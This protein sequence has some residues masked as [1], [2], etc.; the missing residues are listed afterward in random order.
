MQTWQVNCQSNGLLVILITGLVLASAVLFYRRLRGSIPRGRWGLLL[1]LRLVGILVLLLL[2][3]KPAIGFRAGSAHLSAP[4]LLVDVSKSMG[5]ADRPGESR[6]EFVKGLLAEN[7]DLLTQAPPAR[8]FT[9]A[10]GLAPVA[11]DRLESLEAGG[12][13]TDL[14]GALRSVEQAISTDRIQAVVLFSDGNHLGPSDPVAAAAGL[15]RPV[16]S[17][18]VGSADTAYGTGR[19]ALALPDPPVKMI[20]GADNPVSTEVRWQSLQPGNWRL[21]VA[22]NEKRG[23]PKTIALTT[24]AG[25]RTLEVKIRPDGAG[26]TVCRLQL[27]GPA[28]QGVDA[29]APREFHTL[30]VPEKIRVLMVEGQVRPEYKFLKQYLQSDPAVTFAGF[31][32]IRPGKFLVTSLIPGYQP[33][34]LPTTKAEFDRFDLVILGDISPRTFSPGQVRCLKDLVSGGRGLLLIPGQETGDLK[35]GPLADLL[36][37]VLAPKTAWIDSPFLPRLTVAGR[38]AP[39][40]KGLENFFRNDARLQ[41]MFAVGPALPAAR[42]LLAH[43]N[44]SPVLAIRP[45]GKGKTAVLTVESTWRWALN[46]S[47]V[48]RDGLY[49]AFWG[50]LIRDLANREFAAK[51]DPAILVNLDSNSVQAGQPVKIRADLFDNASR[52]ITAAAVSAELL[53]DEKVVATIPLT[54]RQDHY[55]GE[56]TVKEAGHYRIQVRSGAWADSVP[57]AVYTVDEELRQVALNKKLMDDIAAAGQTA[58]MADP[59]TLGAILRTLREQFA[60]RSDK[61]SNLRQVRAFDHRNL[62]LTVFLVALSA[63]WLLRYRWR[64]K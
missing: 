29:D 5:V 14:A 53:K 43:P 38:A 13:T 18:G 22:V 45:L 34:D 30:A 16:H 36:P 23:D 7:M 27:A 26:K 59:T 41:G 33:K 24:P 11:L 15:G 6:L 8:V 3:F 28:G 46:P 52:P 2:V 63:E 19:L 9:F 32:Q 37:V 17:L 31:V 50:Q 56:T 10:D 20:A 44:G 40:F 58:K 60:A 48:L 1:G 25:R 54:V 35:G 21:D 47:P 4:V 42:V 64:L 12:Q 55:A 62:L 39:A 51:Q 61:E 57:V 49:K